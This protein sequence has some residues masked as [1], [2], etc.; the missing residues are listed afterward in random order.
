MLWGRSHSS[1]P[2]PPQDEGA[3]GVGRAARRPP[4]GPIPAPPA[5]PAV[6]GAALLALLRG[7]LHLP[8]AQHLLQRYPRPLFLGGKTGDIG[9]EN[10]IF[11]F[12]G[13]FF[14]APHPR[15]S[16]RRGQLRRGRPPARLPHLQ[17]RLEQGKKGSAMR[18]PSFPGTFGAKFVGFRNF[19]GC[20]SPPRRSGR[21]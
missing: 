5:P 11:C 9:A 2:P 3:L 15:F 13:F 8:G 7:L 6:P 19:W 4:P 12:F 17:L 10:L 1:P 18:D 14:V 16:R 21:G 20:F